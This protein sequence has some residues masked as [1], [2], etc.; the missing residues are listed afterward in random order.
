MG[1]HRALQ[2]LRE[3]TK[4]WQPVTLFWLILLAAG[5]ALGYQQWVV[6]QAGVGGAARTIIQGLTLAA[7]FIIVGVAV[8]F[9]GWAGSRDKQDA[10]FSELVATAVTS[11][12]R[13]LPRTLAAVA[14]FAAGF[15]T[16]TFP[17][18]QWAVPLTL[19]IVPALTIYLI[20]MV[21][22]GALGENL[23]A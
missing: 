4:H 18:I 14:I 2:Y 1:S 5:A 20:R 12:F 23:A 21:L 15:A 3:L 11:T 22:A 7:A 8:W 13:H 17:P 6:A 9:F 10:P 16:V 19:I